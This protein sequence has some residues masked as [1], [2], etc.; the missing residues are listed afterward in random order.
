MEQALGKSDFLPKEEHAAKPFVLWRPTAK[1][2]LM[3]WLT[4]VDHKRIGF[5]Y[6]GCALL[7]LSSAASRPS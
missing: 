7:F 6:G 1:T 2:G 5:L 4:T 3:S